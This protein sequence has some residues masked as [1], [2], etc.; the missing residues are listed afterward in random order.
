MKKLFLC[1]VSFIIMVGYGTS[2]S[3]ILLPGSNEATSEIKLLDAKS[4]YTSTR[5]E[6]T[7]TAYSLKEVNT[8]QGIAYVVEAPK[9][10]RILKKGAP[11]LPLYA[12]SVIIP[13]TDEMEIVVLN[14]KYIEIPNVSVAPSKGNLLRTVNPADV[15]YSYGIEYQQDAYFPANIAYLREPY[16]LRDF[17][18]QAL[19]IQP[20]QYNPATKTLRIYTNLVIEVRSTGKQGINLFYRTKNLTAIDREFNEIYKRQFVNYETTQKYTPLSD[21]PG[22]MLIICHDNYMSAMQPFVAWKIMKGIPTTMVGVSTIG[23]NV[24]SIKIT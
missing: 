19:V 4:N 5:V 8:P 23:N 1:L 24:T 21:L 2:Q 16:I 7:L 13:D 17:R 6:F 20:I 12:K 10:S 18:A 11:D 14:S 3:W 22:N 15:P 9:A